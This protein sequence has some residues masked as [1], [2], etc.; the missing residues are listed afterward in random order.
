MISTLQTEE[1]TSQ[2]SNTQQTEELIDDSTQE[3]PT[4]EN[5]EVSTDSSQDFSKEDPPNF[6]DQPRDTEVPE[7]DDDQDRMIDE[8]I[9]ERRYDSATA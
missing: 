8:P 4:K 3:V 2:R 9:T 6:M 7:V 1:V 5:S